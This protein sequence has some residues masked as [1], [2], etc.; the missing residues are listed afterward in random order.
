MVISLTA[1]FRLALTKATPHAFFARLN[2]RPD[3]PPEILMHRYRSHTCGALR[4]SDIG[5]VVRLSGWCHRIRD[6]GGVP[7]I[8]GPLGSRKAGR[9]PRR[10][11]LL[12]AETLRSEWSRA[13]EVRCGPAEL[14]NPDC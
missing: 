6:H 3:S 8:C 13:R 11:V 5:S 12:R 1:G 2:S 10:K 14:E 9:R 7:S 4:E